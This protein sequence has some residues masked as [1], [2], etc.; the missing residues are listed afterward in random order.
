MNAA[1]KNA[2]KKYILW[3]AKLIGVMLFYAINERKATHTF[4]FFLMY[5]ENSIFV[6]ADVLRSSPTVFFSGSFQANF[7]FS[8]GS[9]NYHPISEYT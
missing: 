2:K 3:L 4:T 1:E 7:N 6:V 5:C 8:C 9:R